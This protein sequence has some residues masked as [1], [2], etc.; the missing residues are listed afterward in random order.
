MPSDYTFVENSWGNSFYK[1][2]NTRLNYDDAKA[3]CESDGSFM[4]FPRSQ[5]ENQFLQDVLPNEWPYSTWIGINDIDQE[6]TFVGPDGNEIS[7]TNWDGSE[8]NGH[9]WGPEHDEDGAIMSKGWGKWMDVKLSDLN[10]FICSF[11]I[12]GIIFHWN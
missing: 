12:E 4:A 3:Q 9:L 2:Y 6:G 7:W 11:D 10:Q 8:P 1:F 5:K